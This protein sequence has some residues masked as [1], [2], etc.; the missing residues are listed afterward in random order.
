[1]VTEKNHKSTCAKIYNTQVGSYK[2]YGAVVNPFL[3]LWPRQSF[4]TR[5]AGAGYCELSRD[6]TQESLTVYLYM[7]VCVCVCV[8]LKRL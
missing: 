1:M 8:R 4:S 2:P 3:R 5:T 7:N 6:S